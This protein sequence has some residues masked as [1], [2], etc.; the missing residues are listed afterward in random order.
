M[1]WA[2]IEVVLWDSD[3][4]PSKLLKPIDTLGTQIPLSTQ[5]ASWGLMST[6]ALAL[7]RPCWPNPDVEEFPPIVK[8]HCVI[9]LALIRRVATNI[10]GLATSTSSRIS[11]WVNW[12]LREIPHGKNVA[13]SLSD[14]KS[15]VYEVIIRKNLSCMACVL[16]A[17][18]LF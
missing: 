13:H 17:I 18:K 1:R 3:Q 16:A 12:C 5:R 9:A 6:P 15:C 11:Q 10:Q 4:S 14:M 7:C 2:K 8:L